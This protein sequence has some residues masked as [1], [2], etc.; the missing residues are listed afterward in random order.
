MDVIMLRDLDYNETIITLLGTPY[1][2]VVRTWKRGLEHV[3]LSG[4]RESRDY[5][6]LGEVPRVPPPAPK[7]VSDLVRL[8]GSSTS[9]L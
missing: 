5:A 2:G 7:A 6:R 8:G 3:I 1:S 4:L 9:H